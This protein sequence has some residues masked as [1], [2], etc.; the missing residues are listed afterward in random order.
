[1]IGNNLKTFYYLKKKYDDFVD[2]ENN[3]E[4]Y[5]YYSFRDLKDKNEW[6][7]FYFSE[8]SQNVKYVSTHMYGKNMKVSDLVDLLPLIFKKIPENTINLVNETEETV[9]QTKNLSET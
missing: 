9:G 2:A 5:M 3:R 6:S 4:I 7:R 8:N 1:M